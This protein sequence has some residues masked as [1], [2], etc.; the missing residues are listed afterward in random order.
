MDARASAPRIAA[1]GKEPR[2]GPGT[3][4]PLEGA[5]ISTWVTARIVDELTAR[6]LDADLLLRAQGLTKSSL[7]DPAGFISARAQSAFFRA[8]TVASGDPAFAVAAGRRMPLER[9]HLFGLV[10]AASATLGAAGEACGRYARL[11]TDSSSVT[12]VGRGPDFDALWVE[13]FPAVVE[14][15]LS[16][17]AQFQRF[18]AEAPRRPCPVT[19]FLLPCFPPPGAERIEAALGAPVQW[20]APRFELRFE[21]GAFETEL[22]HANPALRALIV[23]VADREL[24]MRPD[25][26]LVTRVQGAVLRLGF[27]RSRSLATVARALGTS[28][29]TLQRLLAAG[30]LRFTSVREQVLREAALTMLQEPGATV[31][32]V[33]HRLGFGSRSGFH[34]AVHRWTGASPGRLRGAQA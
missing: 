17:A 19:H 4:L 25:Q 5:R 23:A 22:E 11:V 12:M 13:D 18:A 14:D 16:V 15:W 24:A 2:R 3:G 28:P 6:G 7:A 1:G 29:R 20:L 9:M 32:A 33:A 10:A 30:G 8:A 26:P 27:D 34:R 31:E 21:R